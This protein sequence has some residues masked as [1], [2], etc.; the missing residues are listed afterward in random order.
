MATRNPISTIS[1]NTESFLRE[2]L[3]TWVEQHLIQAYQYIKHKGEDGDKDHIH[4]R[5]EPNKT[6]DPMDLSD[7]LKE[8]V[9]GESLP[10]G[11][12]PWRNA[13]EETWYLYA[14][15]DP[16]FLKDEYGGGEKGEKIPYDWHDIQVSQGYDLEI[17]FIRAKASQKH[18]TPN[19]ARRLQRGE[20][21]LN[22]VLQGENVYTV[23]ALTRF[24]AGTDY[25]RLMK[26]YTELERDYNALVSAIV[27][28]GFTIVNTDDG[29]VC[30]LDN[31]DK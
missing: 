22:M 23:S 2:K 25:D 21:P 18:T 13:K 17:A 26:D 29:M 1:Y 14:V 10:R 30:L 16:E 19:M 11:C 9:V 24:L 12:R 20:N 15:H 28:K 8:F 4:L 7:K 5:I 6:L 31:A 3:D 27:S